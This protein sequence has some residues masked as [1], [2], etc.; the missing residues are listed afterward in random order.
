[1]REIS[2]LDMTVKDGRY[3]LKGEEFADNM[4]GWALVDVVNNRCSSQTIVTN[5]TLYKE[6]TT[7]EALQKSADSYNLT[8]PS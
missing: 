7:E 3:I 5:C 8:S 2:R 6:Y 1:M 4:K